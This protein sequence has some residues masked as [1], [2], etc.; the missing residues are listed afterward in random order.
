MKG[1]QD[2]AGVWCSDVEEIERVF[3]NYFSNIFKS[4]NPFDINLQHVLQ[5]IF[6]VILMTVIELC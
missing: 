2:D 1:L 5:Y 4:C 3:T 6:P